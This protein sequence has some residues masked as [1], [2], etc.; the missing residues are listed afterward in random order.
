MA[1]SSFI[2]QI[3]DARLLNA[4]DKA[5]VFANVVNRDY[6]G[7]IKQQ[8]DTVKIN[9]IGAVTIG[10]YTKNT[11]FTTGPEALATTEQSLT[12]T[13]QSIS[14]SRSTM[15]TLPRLPVM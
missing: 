12:M 5:H 10:N 14:T 11:D 2:P 6:E 1:I 15:W 3:W 9:T 8:G 7:D 13:R 4:L